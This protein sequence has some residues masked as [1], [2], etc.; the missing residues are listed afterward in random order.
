[1]NFSYVIMD[2]RGERPFLFFKCATYVPELLKFNVKEFENPVILVDS[3][4]LDAQAPDTVRYFQ[5]LSVKTPLTAQTLMI[6]KIIEY[7]TQTV[8]EMDAPPPIVNL[9]VSPVTDVMKD[10]TTADRIPVPPRYK[11]NRYQK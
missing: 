7:N 9:H 2:S 4:A 8:F 11:R 6:R 5:E 3:Y 1:M 10:F